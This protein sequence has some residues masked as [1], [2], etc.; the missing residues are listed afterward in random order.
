MDFELRSAVNQKDYDLVKILI[1]QGADVFARDRYASNIFNE[2]IHNAIGGDSKLLNVLLES[3]ININHKDINLNSCLHLLI[4]DGFGI[5]DHT[6]I[7]KYLISQGA[8][9][10]NTN[11]EL[12]TPLH[13]ACEYYW[14]QPGLVALLLEHKAQ[15][16]AQDIFG[17]TA[18]HRLFRKRNVALLH[19]TECCKTLLIHGANPN[20]KNR[21]GHTALHEAII[22]K[23][24][25]AIVLLLEY[26][27]DPHLKNNEGFTALDVA[28]EAIKQ[29]ILDYISM[30]ISLKEPEE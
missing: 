19:W 24:Q 26:G 3:G 21:D 10:N 6:N 4:S 2:A 11:F 25:G 28:S 17:Y 18:L 14:K 15:P 22:C 12:K 8:D 27:A 23:H 13:V 16:N 1:R 7:I 5:C 29:I 9:V 20:L 30:D